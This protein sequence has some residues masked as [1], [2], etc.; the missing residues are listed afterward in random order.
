[1]FK[2]GISPSFQNFPLPLIKGKGDNGGW[3]HYPKVKEVKTSSL[4][5]NGETV[6][7]QKLHLLADCLLFD[8]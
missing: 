4:Q 7:S 2:R 8:K 6:L 5:G 1:V 3:G